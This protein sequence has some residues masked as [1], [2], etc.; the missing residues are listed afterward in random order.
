M[1][2]AT[3]MNVVGCTDLSGKELHRQV[4]LSSVVT[5][6]SLDGVMVS[7]MTRNVRAVG[8]ISALGA[9]F[10]ISV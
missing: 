3:G 2:N 9:I 1:Y 5:A 4:G 7:T 10:P 8:S 6:G